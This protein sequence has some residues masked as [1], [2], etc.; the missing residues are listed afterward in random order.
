[1]LE[2]VEGGMLVWMGVVGAEGGA[3]ASCAFGRCCWRVRLDWVEGR[4][5]R[6]LRLGGKKSLLCGGAEAVACWMC[7]A[8]VCV[9]VVVV[10]FW[11]NG[12]QETAS[13]RGRM[14]YLNPQGRGRGS[15]PAFQAGDETGQGRAGAARRREAQL[16]RDRDPSTLSTLQKH[17]PG[18]LRVHTRIPHGASRYTPLARVGLHGAQWPIPSVPACTPRRGRAAAI[19]RA[20]AG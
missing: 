12:N 9:V 16:S 20:R 17:S 3:S 4:S 18:C 7:L 10:V 2:V 11:R 14:G 8:G 15:G 13:G 6:R 19:L 5:R 1:M